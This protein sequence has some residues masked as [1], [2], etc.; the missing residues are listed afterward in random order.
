M[1]QGV[2][3]ALTKFSESAFFTDFEIIKKRC[4]DKMIAFNSS[5]PYFSY[6]EQDV[7]LLNKVYDD[8]SKK[9][10][11]ILLMV[12]AD[13][14]DKKQRK[15][16]VKDT[17]AYSDELKVKLSEADLYYKSNFSPL[18]EK[19]TEGR[20]AGAVI[21]DVIKGIFGIVYECFNMYLEMRKEFASFRA[22]VVD[23]KFNHLTLQSSRDLEK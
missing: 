9:F 20:I 3:P 21:E 8:C 16:I 12:K 5:K 22:S 4:E 2:Y 7:Q 6:S 1:S 17:K 23:T 15:I 10:N 14:L 11:D 13:L 19:I 18:L